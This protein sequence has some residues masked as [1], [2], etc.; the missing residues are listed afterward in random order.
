MGEEIPSP[1]IKITKK[2][3]FFFFVVKGDWWQRP[4]KSPKW[5]TENQGSLPNLTGMIEASKIARKNRSWV[6]S[7][8]TI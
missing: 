7:K 5:M 2:S 8:N 4:P 3:G 6:S 1:P